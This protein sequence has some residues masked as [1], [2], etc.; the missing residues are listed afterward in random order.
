[1]TDKT[2]DK[3]RIRPPGSHN[4]FASSGI[5]A[6]RRNKTAWNTSITNVGTSVPTTT[7]RTQTSQRSSCSGR[8]KKFLP[9][10][11]GGNGVVLACAW[12]EG[13]ERE[14]GEEEGRGRVEEE[15]GSFLLWLMTSSKFQV[16][17]SKFE[18]HSLLQPTNH[19]APPALGLFLKTRLMC[20]LCKLLN[21]HRKLG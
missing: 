17:C 14:G 15:E 6:T 11:V 7:W 4:N 19:S 1:M 18:V 5:L 16:L 10:G 8:E 9:F 20:T 12:E 3:R 21:S 13:E 2:C